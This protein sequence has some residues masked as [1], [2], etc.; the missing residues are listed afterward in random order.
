M[1][2]VDAEAK[3]AKLSQ[4]C[5]KLKQQN[6]VLKQA[7]TEKQEECTKLEEAAKEH[8][9]VLR[10][11]LEEYDAIQYQKDRQISQLT[12][13]LDEMKAAA[14]KSGGGWLSFG[15][16]SA[17]ALQKLEKEL[18]IVRE[19]LV[20]KIQENEEIHM[21]TFSANKQ[22]QDEVEELKHQFDKTKL[23]LEQQVDELQGMIEQCQ[24][25]E[26]ASRD[27]IKALKVELTAAV[28]ERDE[29]NAKIEEI[30]SSFEQLKVDVLQA[31]IHHQQKEARFRAESQDFLKTRGRSVTS[32]S[33]AGAEAQVADSANTQCIELLSEAC[34]LFAES[35]DLWVSLSASRRRTAVGSFVATRLRT[36]SAALQQSLRAIPGFARG[37]GQ[38]KSAAVRSLSRCHRQWAVLQA[39]S[40]E[41]HP[42]HA[43]LA[44]ALYSLHS[45]ICAICAATLL[46]GGT[47]AEGKRGRRPVITAVEAQDRVQA[48]LIDVV[49]RMGRDWDSLRRILAMRKPE[50][51]AAADFAEDAHTGLL[52]IL[53]RLKDLTNKRLVGAIGDYFATLQSR[54]KGEPGSTRALR[55]GAEGRIALSKVKTALVAVS[56]AAEQQPQ[57]QAE[58]VRLECELTENSHEVD[59]LQEELR[60]VQDSYALLQANNEALRQEEA[61]RQA[62]S[63]AG[64]SQRASF[65]PAPRGAPESENWSG[66]VPLDSEELL[67]AEGKGHTLQVVPP[68]PPAEDRSWAKCRTWEEEIAKSYD[69]RL[70]QIAAQLQ[71]AD[72]KAV[73]LNSELER[74]LHFV[75]DKEEEKREL[76]Q[77][78]DSLKAKVGEH[79][80]SMEATKKNYDSQMKM[81][82]E[83]I[84]KQSDQLAQKDTSF[85]ALIGAKVQ[86]GRCGTWN[87]VGYLLEEVA[88]GA[89]KTCKGRVLERV[90]EGKP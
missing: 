55:L 44:P 13:Q 86:C 41:G 82:T 71:A 17:E 10:K 49:T 1:A 83:H 25:R 53:L 87:N 60:A 23:H 90:A 66:D 78:V 67:A 32:L 68:H 59:R 18:E 79:L 43:L 85:S 14:Q 47:I 45:R 50:P 69:K 9:V 62:Q 39:A 11:Q 30:T 64:Q 74:A 75:K 22:H 63:R 35:L 16:N 42:S 27:E 46:V 28:S 4:R 72:C 26:Q 40:C 37:G 38:N 73:E 51:D 33:D 21:Q 20:L 31:Q 54:S 84:M 3:I 65:K 57:L 61:L 7:F 88:T 2:E 52:A 36:S 81:L 76:I 19:D 15:G 70:R 34:N 8:E 24:H 12:K 48:H 6:T 89:C 80:E 5:D 58:L 29:Q 77:Q 56:E